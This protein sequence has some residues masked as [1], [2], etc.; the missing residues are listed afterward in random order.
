MDAVTHAAAVAAWV[1]LGAGAYHFVGYPLLVILLAT[2]RGQ[3]PHPAPPGLPRVAMVI[4]AYNEEKVIAAKLRNSLALDYPPGLL[5][6]I[7]VADGSSDATAERVR[8]FADE[9]VTCLF[10]PVRRGKGHA[11]NRAV[12]AAQ[13]DVLVLSDANNDYSTDA[14]RLLVARL[15]QPGVAGVSGA[16][17][18][19]ASRERAASGGDGLYW[20][21]ESRIKAAESGLGGT[22]TAD[23]EVFALRRDAYVPI[24]PGVVNDDLFLTLRIVEQGGAVVYEPR[25]TATEEASLTMLEDYRTKVRMIAGG[26]QDLRREWRA[27]CSSPSFALKF[28]SHKILRWTMPLFLLLALAG[29]AIASAPG[30]VLRA[31]LLAQVAFYALAAVGWGLN[32]AG[33]RPTPFYVPFYFLLMNIA[34]VAA[35]VRCFRGGQSTLWAKAAR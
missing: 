29:S 26:L 13:A 30:S 9:R 20:R 10:D 19:V 6:I 28:V 12:A 32:R 18:I 1:G 24:P 16:K 17:R 2:L 14:I 35:M 7:V 34:A 3:R 5:S 15:A 22:V 33:M 27:I 4:A 8:A 25:A 31:L 21:Y 11:L 23:G